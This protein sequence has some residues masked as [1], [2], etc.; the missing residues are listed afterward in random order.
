MKKPGTLLLICNLVMASCTSGLIGSK[1]ANETADVSS[2][3]SKE[4]ITPENAERILKKYIID[5]EI[6]NPLYG[7]LENPTRR[8]DPNHEPTINCRGALLNDYS[9]EAHIL[10]QCDSDSLKGEQCEVFRKTYYKNNV[11]EGTFRILLTMES[12][13]SD[14]SM[15]P[16]YWAFYIENSR[17]VMIEPSEI[18][19]SPVTAANDSVYSAYYRKNSPRNL[20]K[21]TITLYFKNMTFFGQNMFSPENP[22]IVLVMSRKQKIVARIAWKLL[23]TPK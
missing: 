20:I 15:D 5:F 17:G 23:R 22:S 19:T 6:P 4:T 2:A 9:T 12:G 13:F 8:N 11:S 10:F 21:R 18:R 7:G 1:T 3:D 16:D 14:K